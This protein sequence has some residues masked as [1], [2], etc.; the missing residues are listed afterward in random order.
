MVCKGHK[1]PDKYEDYDAG[2]NQIE[3][4]YPA[5]QAVSSLGLKIIHNLDVLKLY[6]QAQ[7]GTAIILQIIMPI[8]AKAT[9]TPIVIHRVLWEL[10]LEDMAEEF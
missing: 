9:I 2:D 10:E 1:H 5:S 6:N 4:P 8:I 3:P 7:S